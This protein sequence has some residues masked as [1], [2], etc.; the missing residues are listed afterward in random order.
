MKAA[1]E[2][3]AALY[4]LFQP[5]GVQ[6]QI[7]NPVEDNNG[8]FETQFVSFTLPI[9]PFD[10]DFNQVPGLRLDSLKWTESGWMLEG[11]LYGK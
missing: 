4:D 10:I 11:K 2:E 8:G 6:A 7:G 9:S 1:S 3:D 5:I